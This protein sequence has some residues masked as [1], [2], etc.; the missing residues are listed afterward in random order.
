[1]RKTALLVALAAALVIPAAGSAGGSTAFA[2]PAGDAAA[3]DIT[4]VTVSN[5]DTGLI[6]F[7]VAIPNRPAVTTGLY[8]LVFLNTDQNAA[9][10][11]PNDDGAD[12]V[13]G[14]SGGQA[15][16]GK[17][18]GSDFDFTVPHPSLTSTYA[19]GVTLKVSA[20]DLGGTTGFTFYV[21]ADE[22]AADGTPQVDFAPDA[23]APDFTYAVQITPPAA[24]PPIAAKPAPKPKAKPKK[25]KH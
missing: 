20:A 4:G 9:T 7:A 17:W 25:K 12:Y 13:L 19:G 16:L 23:S 8:V 11:A 10:G 1:M 6:T 24:K 21:V 3:A 22:H 15:E 2:D 5:D 14:Y 18:T